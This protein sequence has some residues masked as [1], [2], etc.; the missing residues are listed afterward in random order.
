MLPAGDVGLRVRSAVHVRD[1]GRDNPFHGD[2]RAR[3]DRSGRGFEP[4]NQRELVKLFRRFRRECPGKTLWC[5]S[6]YTWE[7][8]TGES[9]ARCE[10]TDE[11]L[12]YLD[13]LVDGEFIESKKSLMIRFRGSTNQRVIDV[14]KT[15]ASGSIVLWCD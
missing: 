15:L 11:M 5:Y 3:C 14:P 10:V 6:G 13:V 8:L 12:S 1:R 4:D 7:E 9:R 2:V